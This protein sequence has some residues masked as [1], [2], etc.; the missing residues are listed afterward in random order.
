MTPWDS[1]PVPSF[2][3]GE[4]VWGILERRHRYTT[5]ITT[6][7]LSLS[8]SLR[9]RHCPTTT[10]LP[11]SPPPRSITLGPVDTILNAIRSLRNS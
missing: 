4:G 10:T 1:C 5:A 2:V 11:S 6:A 8:L 7:S 3:E 9:Y